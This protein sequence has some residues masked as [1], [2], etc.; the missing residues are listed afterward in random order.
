M[1]EAKMVCDCSDDCVFE[2]AHNAAVDTNAVQTGIGCRNC[3]T[4][5]YMFSAERP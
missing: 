5:R 3:V 4:E 2:A 1:L